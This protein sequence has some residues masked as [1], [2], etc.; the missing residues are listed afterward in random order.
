MVTGKIEPCISERN[1][2]NKS[3]SRLKKIA[4]YFG[5]VQHV[6]VCELLVLFPVI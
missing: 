1:S 6:P 5:T 2:R 4:H 3:C